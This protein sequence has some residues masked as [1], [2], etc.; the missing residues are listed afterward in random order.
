VF[1]RDPKGNL[2]KHGTCF[3]FPT[4]GEQLTEAGLD[5]AYY[6]AV[7]GQPGYFWN[8]YNGVGNVFHTDLWHEHVRSVEHLLRDIEAEDLPAVT[9]VTPRFQLSDH[10]PFST[11]H[12]HNWVTD[13][14][15][16]VMRSP[17]WEHTAIF[18]T[19]DE[20]GGFYD[21]ILPPQIDPVG[22]G[23][24]VPMLTISPYARRG[25]IDDELGEFSTPLRFISDNWGLEPL[26]DRIRNTHNFEHVFN[27]SKGP[28]A[29]DIAD[30][31]APT[32]GNAFGW[33]ADT[34][35]G[36]EPG[37]TPVPDPL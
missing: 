11:G 7:P 36:W 34:Y 37:T 29:P 1:V 33:P 6:S 18:L 19:W 13:I 23:I 4:V 15:N 32:F 2:T 9:W 21:P 22:L 8:A 5:W 35:P 31:R 3:E 25:V 17:M 24:R 27:F 28:R 20:W 30:E 26:T 14:V 10:P 12:A 16:T